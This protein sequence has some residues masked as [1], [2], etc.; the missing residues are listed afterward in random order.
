[1]RNVKIKLPRSLE[2]RLLLFFYAEVN[3]TFFVVDGTKT[4]QGVIEKN[5]AIVTFSVCSRKLE[6]LCQ[7]YIS[8]GT[9]S[10]VKTEFYQNKKT[11]I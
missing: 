8:V 3:I 4:R 9:V 11:P 2:D 10:N 7:I 5:T 6:S 1:M